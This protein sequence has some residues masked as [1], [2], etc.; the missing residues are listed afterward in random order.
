MSLSRHLSVFFVVFIAYAHCVNSELQYFITPSP[1][2]SCLT[3]SQ[4]D[5]LTLSQ[6]AATS[7]NY[8][9]HE[10]EV[11]LLFLSGNHSL[12]VGLSLTELNNI[13]IIK[14]SQGNDSE[15]A[16][17]ECTSHRVNFG[18]SNVNFAIISGIHFQTTK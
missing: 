12:D 10:T 16:V 7:N 14:E 5:C 8:I 6:F 3:E 18:I 2:D 4:G 11:V 13:S 9:G 1:D 17:I 15:L